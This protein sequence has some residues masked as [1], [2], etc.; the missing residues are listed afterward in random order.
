MNYGCK[1]LQKHSH[2]NYITNFINSH[3][4]LNSQREYDLNCD[5]KKSLVFGVFE[6]F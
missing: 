6:G 2:F 5:H 1:C 3:F 4:S